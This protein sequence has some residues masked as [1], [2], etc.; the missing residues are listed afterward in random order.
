M[1]FSH[2]GSGLLFGSGCHPPFAVYEY[3]ESLTVEVSTFNLLV[4][5]DQ[6]LSNTF[7]PQGG[8]SFTL[9]FRI[10]DTKQANAAVFH[11]ACGI[12]TPSTHS[13]LTVVL[14]T[15]F[16]HELI[17]LTETKCRFTIV[18][19]KRGQPRLLSVRHSSGD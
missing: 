17:E 11:T 8:Q 4:E 18:C 16:A 15:S 9:S 12:D 10:D 6:S 13:T 19:P 3:A 5:L 1:L 14:G 2:E 7:C